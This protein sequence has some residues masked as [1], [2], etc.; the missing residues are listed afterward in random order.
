[1]WFFIPAFFSFFFL[2]LDWSNLSDS[3]FLRRL[4]L[5]RYIYNVH[6]HF[7]TSE[8]VYPNFLVSLHY[9][10]SSFIPFFSFLT[11]YSQRRCRRCLSCVCMYV[12]FTDC[13]FLFVGAYYLSLCVLCD[14]KQCVAYKKSRT[15]TTFVIQVSSY[16]ATLRFDVNIIYT[17]AQYSTHTL[18]MYILTCMHKKKNS[19]HQF[20]VYQRFIFNSNMRGA[21]VPVAVLLLLLKCVCAG[22]IRI[23]KK[24][25]AQPHRILLMTI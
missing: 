3:W 25:V 12:K 2:Q 16:S 15:V 24:A 9:L 5:R 21:C 18:N 6:T 13:V 4:D 10:F 1:M 7:F 19:R 23:R 14:S 22:V 8:I 17:H 20:Y 11:F